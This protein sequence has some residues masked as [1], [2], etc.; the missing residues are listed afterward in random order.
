MSSI[1]LS[2]E[3]K[4]RILEHR[5]YPNET[6]EQCILRILKMVEDDESDLLTEQDLKDI[7]EGLEQVKNG[8]F[9]TLEQMLKEHDL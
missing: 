3:T 9:F 1:Q 4:D 6:Y 5:L 7:E 8:K 2:K